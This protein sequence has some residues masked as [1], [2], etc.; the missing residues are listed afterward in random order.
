MQEF[1]VYK[2]FYKDSNK[3][4]YV[5]KGS[6]DRYKDISRRNQIFKSIY[7]KNPENCQVEI[8]Q[9]FSDEQEAFAYEE[10]IIEKYQTFGECEA[11]LYKGGAGGYKSQWTQEMKDYLSEYNPM[12]ELENRMNNHLNSPMY[13]PEIVKKCVL[14]H[15]YQVVIDGI[16][17]IS[18]A[19][20]SRQLNL[21]PGTI[22]LWVRRGYSKKKNPCYLL[23]NER[24]IALKATY[25]QKTHHNAKAIIIDDI[26]Y[27][28]ISAAA[29]AIGGRAECLSK[30]LLAGKTTYKGHTCR[31]ADQQPSQENN[32]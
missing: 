11:N 9:Y 22:G 12:Y 18:M 27:P 2:W 31:Y 1:Y 24:D 20:A 30:N 29:K 4:F 6:K 13:N 19:E 3:V 5:G 16:T 8:I 28:T 17:Y 26:E 14:A 32:Q 23:N 7:N 10:K 25:I 15:N 21:A